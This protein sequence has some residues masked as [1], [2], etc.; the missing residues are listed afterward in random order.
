[1]TG[2]AAEVIPVVEI[3]SRPIGD[4]HVGQTTR[5]LISEFKKMVTR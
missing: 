3:D 2:S 1:L 4:G 5:L